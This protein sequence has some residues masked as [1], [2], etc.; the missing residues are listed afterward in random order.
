MVRS[1][2]SVAPGYLSFQ[3]MNALV[4]QLFHFGGR[5][6]APTGARM[7]KLNLK[8]PETEL[9]QFVVAVRNT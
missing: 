5:G 8:L 3:P 1:R 7:L 6:D 4:P 2:L 9:L